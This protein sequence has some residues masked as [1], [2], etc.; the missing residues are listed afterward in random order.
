MTQSRNTPSS[1]LVALESEVPMSVGSKSAHAARQAAHAANPVSL[2][3]KALLALC[4]LLLAVQLVP[5]TAWA[6]SG[7]S[8]SSTVAAATRDAIGSANPTDAPSAEDG[9]GGGQP[10]GS[11]PLATLSTEPSDDADDGQ[12]QST[13]NASPSATVP[14]ADAKQGVDPAAD[15]GMK[16]DAE[17]TAEPTAGAEKT[18]KPTTEAD[19]AQT[20][21]VTVRVI[22]PDA[23]GNDADWLAATSVALPS[24]KTA[25]DASEAAF[26]AA[27]LGYDAPDTGYGA[28]LSTITSPFNGKAYGWDES[29][30]CFWQFFVNGGSSYDGASGVT[31]VDG[32][33][34]V[35]YYSAWGAS[36][37]G[38]VT[39]N[40]AHENEGVIT[41]PETQRPDYSSE[42]PGFAKGAAGSGGA[43]VID[44]P[45]PVNGAKLL[46]SVPFR[47]KSSWAQSDPVI[48]GD[49]IF[50]VADGKL[51][52]HDKKTGKKGDSVALASSNVY[53][54]RPV[55]ADGLVIV[56]LDDGR[57]QAFT[58]DSLT[59]VW[60]TDKI[61]DLKN[62][63]AL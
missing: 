56:P 51:V 43:V 13:G 59:C 50:M 35:W 19:D 16:A 54:C 40:P 31:P 10:D 58:A 61:D 55:Y 30:G 37:S 48:V 21:T 23:E 12:A 62:T 29:T 44:V 5:G 14:A 47:A 9:S 20:V 46:W 4:S 24:G 57:M 33:S 52:V 3:R 2:P 15:T 6:T 53:F 38:T 39:D 27:G 26:E 11:E 41:H 1:Y 17:R 18:A 25:W 7:E 60:I 36:P 22:G 32:D 42:W 45:T 63:Q 8:P 49:R 34:V 28:Y